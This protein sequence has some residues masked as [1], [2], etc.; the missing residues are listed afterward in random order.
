[1]Q[2]WGHMR[3]KSPKT[4]VTAVDVH[5]NTTLA[6]SDRALLIKPGTDGALALAI[7]HVILTEGLWDKKFVGDFHDGVNRF[8]TGQS[9]NPALFKEKWVKGLV[10][11]WNIELKDRTP[12]WAAEVTTIL[13]RDIRNTAIEFGSTRPA[14]AIFERGVHAHSNGIYN[15]M[16][17]H[18]LNAL[19]GALFS[20]GGMM[21]Q[22]GPAYGPMQVSAQD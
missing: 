16:A 4:R 11:W 21:Y 3:S 12:E 2:M 17:V 22:M 7:A 20:K 13:E 8:K 15:G 9:V 6:A 19:V 5:M 14:M 1:M 10:E 18:A